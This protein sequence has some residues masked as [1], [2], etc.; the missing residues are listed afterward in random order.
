MQ[1]PELWQGHGNTLQE[2][3]ASL[4]HPCSCTA[5]LGLEPAQQPRQGRYALTQRELSLIQRELSLPLLTLLLW[6]QTQLSPSLIP[7]SLTATLYG[8]GAAPQHPSNLTEPKP[9]GSGAGCSSTTNTN[10]A[11]R[12]L[13]PGQGWM[14]LTILPC[15]HHGAGC[16]SAIPEHSKGCKCESGKRMAMLSAGVTWLCSTVEQQL[17]GAADNLI[18]LP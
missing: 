2:A 15:S 11:A 13:E 14:L 10:I 12:A 5:M 6:A 18:K 8:G 1:S 16:T 7:A 17:F 9:L 3:K 4:Q